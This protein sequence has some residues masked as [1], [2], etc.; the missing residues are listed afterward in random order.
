MYKQ[1]LNRRQKK[2]AYT[3]D[4]TRFLIKNSK[5]I[6]AEEISEMPLFNSRTAKQI[7]D[8]CSRIG[9]GYISRKDAA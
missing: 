9:C 6:T 1:Q 2:L 7:K 8:Q 3:D 4:Q 5:V